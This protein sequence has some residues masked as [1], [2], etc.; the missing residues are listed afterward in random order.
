MISDASC[1]HWMSSGTVWHGEYLTRNSSEYPKDADMSFLSDILEKD[2]QQ[3]YYLSAK[4]C[5]GILRRAEKRG[6]PLPQ[7]LID[8]LM[9]LADVAQCM[10]NCLQVI[11]PAEIDWER[12]VRAVQKHNLERGRNEMPGARTLKIDWH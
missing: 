3:K 1:P 12:A 11:D 10:C 4:A 2:P 5:D 8:A 6:K 9:E 7:K